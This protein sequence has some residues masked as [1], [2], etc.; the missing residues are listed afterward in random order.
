MVLNLYAYTYRSHGMRVGVV[1]LQRQR[2]I[3]SSHSRLFDPYDFQGYVPVSLL[4]ENQSWL[5][6]YGNGSFSESYYDY[7]PYYYGGYSDYGDEYDN[8][9]Y[10]NDY[11]E[12]DYY[13]DEQGR[14]NYSVRSTVAE[15]NFNVEPLSQVYDRNY[16]TES[17]A[18]IRLKRETEFIRVR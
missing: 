4:P 10:G 1:D 2:V 18:N 3:R 7:D 15:G 12:E 17:G 9:Y 13:E 14:P 6:D 16:R 5:L 8:P 11:Y